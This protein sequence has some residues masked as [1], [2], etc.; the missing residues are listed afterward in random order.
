MLAR[1]PKTSE[2]REAPAFAIAR[3]DVSGEFFI[4]KV[5]DIVKFKKSEH[6]LRH[7]RFPGSTTRLLPVRAG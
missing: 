3:L 4:E 5:R 1:L 7:A 6:V 2:S